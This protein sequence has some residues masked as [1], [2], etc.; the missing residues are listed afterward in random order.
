MTRDSQLGFSHGNIRFELTITGGLMPSDY[1]ERFDAIMRTAV[2]IINLELIPG[3]NSYIRENIPL[4][5]SMLG[6]DTFIESIVAEVKGVRLEL[7]IEVDLSVDLP[8]EDIKR[9][10]HELVADDCLRALQMS[11]TSDF[12]VVG[13][14]GSWPDLVSPL[15][16]ALTIVPSFV[17]DWLTSDRSPRPTKPEPFEAGPVGSTD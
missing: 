17:N 11:M 5:E 14:I 10:I 16:G 15:F 12:S 4:D 9:M 8:D 1:D 7:M 3:I 13:W 6:Q 2:N